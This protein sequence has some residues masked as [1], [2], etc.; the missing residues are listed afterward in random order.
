MAALSI[1]MQNRSLSKYANLPE[2]TPD[3]I[4]SVV[5]TD[6]QVHSDFTTSFNKKLNS[7]IEDEKYDDLD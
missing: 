7:L 5:D 6:I 2:W 1:A 4:H 3:Q